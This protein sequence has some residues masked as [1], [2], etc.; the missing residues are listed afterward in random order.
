MEFSCDQP[1]ANNNVS[2]EFWITQIDPDWEDREMEDEV[3]VWWE[4]GFIW[5]WTQASS[6]NVET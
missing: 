4:W 1:F 6:S 2:I 3:C 5:K